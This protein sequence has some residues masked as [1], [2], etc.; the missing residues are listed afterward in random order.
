MLLSHD[1]PQGIW[2]YGN[3]VQLLRTKPF[4][5]EDMESGRLGSAPLM[6]LLRGLKPSFWFAAHLHVKF[7]AVLFHEEFIVDDKIKR[8]RDDDNMTGM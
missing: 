1:W 8:K 5:K 7:P 2:N 3:A 6:Q 4:L